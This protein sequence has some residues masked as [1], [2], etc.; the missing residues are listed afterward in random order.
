MTIN[1][2]EIDKDSALFILSAAR[3]ALDAV[4]DINATGAL[5]KVAGSLKDRVEREQGEGGWQ[6]VVGRRGTMGCCLSP[7]PDHYFNFDLEQVNAFILYVL[8]DC[9]FCF[10]SWH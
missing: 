1:N 8:Y 4:G 10:F 5:G 2:S 3:Q 9:S 6:C 7:S